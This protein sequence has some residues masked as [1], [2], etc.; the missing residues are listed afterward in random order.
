[1]SKI[2]TRTIV[3][4]ALLMDGSRNHFEG[5]AAPKGRRM[6]ADAGLVVGDRAYAEIRDVLGIK[7]G[8]RGPGVSPTY[9]LKKEN[10]ELRAELD[11]IREAIGMA[12]KS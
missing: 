3:K 10:A 9:R 6:L 7:K 12:V 1:M 4:A 2:T 11:A 5:V 8:K